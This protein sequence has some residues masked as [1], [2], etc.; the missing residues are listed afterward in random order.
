MGNAQ[1]ISQNATPNVVTPSGSVACGNSAS[2]YT[3]DN[4]YYRIFNLTD[5]GI[6]YDYKVTN[7][8][9]GVQTANATLPVDVTL[10]TWAGGVFPN[11]GSPTQIGTTIVTVNP[12]NAG[13]MVDT[14]TSLMAVA[15][16][17][18]QLVVEMYH[19]GTVDLPMSMFYMGTNS[20]NQTGISYLASGTCGMLDPV[21]TGTGALANFASA[22]WVMTVTGQNNTLGTT[23]VINSQ[24]FQVYPNPVKDILKFR[25]SNGLKSEAIE[26]FDMSGKLVTNI[27]NN[28]NVNE[29]NVSHFAKGSYILKVK[30]SD[31]KVYIQK[32]LKD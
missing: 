4:A 8:A 11:A 21:A 10:Y 18:S 20:G 25:F 14:G 30:A 32:M 24:S 29:L 16:A 7:V 23:E 3:A 13:G 27:Q 15:P 17:G 31:G 9:F 2:G 1:V 28:K 5:Y 12:A 22:K 26:I 6:N 19:D